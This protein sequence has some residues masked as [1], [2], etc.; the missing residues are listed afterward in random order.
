[1]INVDLTEV[2]F[3]VVLYFNRS[4]FVILV[5]ADLDKNISAFFIHCYLKT[6]DFLH[7]VLHTLEPINALTPQFE[8]RV[9]T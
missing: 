2:V 3:E 1:M 7:I 5:V 4:M 6:N 9:F 8:G